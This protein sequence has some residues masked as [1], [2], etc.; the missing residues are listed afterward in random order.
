MVTIKGRQLQFPVTNFSYIICVMGKTK[1]EWQIYL[2]GILLPDRQKSQVFMYWRTL[3]T[4][5]FYKG[6]QDLFLH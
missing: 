2:W 6:M 5:K 4:R 3:G 1:S